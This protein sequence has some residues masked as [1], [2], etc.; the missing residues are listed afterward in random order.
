MKKLLTDKSI[1]Q[2]ERRMNLSYSCSLMTTFILAE[3][4]I[5]NN[6]ISIALYLLSVFAWTQ[7]VILK[8]LNEV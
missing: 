4:I 1:A 7:W 6:P 3:Y 2:I 8:L 5:R